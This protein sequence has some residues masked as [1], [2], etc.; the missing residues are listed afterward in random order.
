MLLLLQVVADEVR[1]AQGAA[2][3][4]WEREVRSLK[5]QMSTNQKRL[6][7]LE[8]EKEGLMKSQSASEELTTK[9]RRYAPVAILYPLVCR[10]IQSQDAP[11]GFGTRAYTK[12]LQRHPTPSP[13]AMLHPQP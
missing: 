5:E 13:S 9:L 1:A 2:H 8:R 11:V 10:Q 4:K 6:F 12:M 3:K 7:L